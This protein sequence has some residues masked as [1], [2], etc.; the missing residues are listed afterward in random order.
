MM[1]LHLLVIAIGTL[2]QPAQ[3]T[4]TTPPPATP[5][6]AADREKAVAAVLDQLH[7]LA[8][9]A[10]GAKYFALFA[11]DGIFLGTDATERWTVEQF[12][13]YAKPFFDKGQ[14]WTYRPTQRHI[15]FSASGE[16][17][18]FDELLAN[19]KIGEC[20]GSGVLTKNAQGAWKIAQYNLTKVVPNE[21]MDDVVK[22]I[23]EK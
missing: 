11:P 13:A 21:K 12:K 22:V 2:M 18:W 1:P 20:R 10:D 9:K 4:T 16:L 8:S 17:A 5:A 6:P 19:D 15:H 14:G 3:P 7:E 23:G